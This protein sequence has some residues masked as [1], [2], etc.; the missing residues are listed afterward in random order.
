MSSKKSRSPTVRLTAA[1]AE[2]KKPTHAPRRSAALVHE[3]LDA[4]PAHGDQGDLGRHEDRV[5]Q[6]ED[7]D[8]E[9]LAQRAHQA[10]GPPAGFRWRSRTRAGTPTAIFPGGTSWV[11]TEPAPVAAPSPMVTGATSIVS[12]PMKAPSPITVRCLRV[13]S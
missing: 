3:L 13:P 2:A 8:D 12:E 9:D 4:R 6:D 5:D 10:S 11:T 7:D 1:K